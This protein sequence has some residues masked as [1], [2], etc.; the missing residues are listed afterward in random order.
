MVSISHL[1]EQIMNETIEK[2]M[3]LLLN[4]FWITKDEQKDDYYFLKRNQNKIRNFVSKNLGNKLI[5]HDRFIKLE[6]IPTIAKPTFGIQ[7]FTDV[8]DYVIMFLFL[9]Y[10][11]DKPRGDKFILS[12][13]IQYIRNTAITLELMHIPDWN[14]PASRKSLIRVID[15]FLE[16]HI[17]VLKDQD[18]KNFQDTVE[19]D[20]LYE[21]TGLSNYL[22][23]AFDYDIYEC[24][25]PSDF[26]RKEWGEQTEE[27]GDI[28]RYKIYRHLI[29][30]P[31]TTKDELT[32]SEED[33]LKKM[34]KT[35]QKELMENINMDTEITKNLAYTLADET[36]IQKEYFPNTKNLSDI[37]LIITQRI[38]NYQK[39]KQIP[40]TEQECF[41]L[42]K[43][44][45]EQILKDTRE[46]A[47]EY[48]GKKYLDMPFLKYQ[49]EVMTF[50]R[51]FHFIKEEEHTILCYPL[52]K[53]YLG[54]T[55][56]KKESKAEQL[57]LEEVNYV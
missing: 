46:E 23:P 1:E 41:H 15:Y 45:F 57:E 18:N 49:E 31:A 4:N 7:K 3:N 30:A 47:S 36:T 10:L 51:N 8:E 27:K 34:H 42:T 32:E 5:I 12:S 26:L 11:E 40:L 22:V 43:S 52:V 33:Y 14:Y 24:K 9:L 55:V 6:K 29:Y 37:V 56:K 53:R 20:A 54:K 48:F 17:L 2:E 21:I 16:L 25:T 13:L 50:M 28:R 35:I 44:E 39:E 19:A 38:I